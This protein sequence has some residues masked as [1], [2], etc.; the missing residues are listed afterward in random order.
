MTIKYPQLLARLLAWFAAEVILSYV[1]LDNLA[2]YSEYL[3][4]QTTASIA[5]GCNRF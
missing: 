1:G 5:V 3:K 2:D 4:E